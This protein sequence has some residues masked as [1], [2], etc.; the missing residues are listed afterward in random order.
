MKT[1]QY[2]A[3]RRQHLPQPSGSVFRDG[4]CIVGDGSRLYFA[5]ERKRFAR[6]TRRSEK[7]N[8]VLLSFDSACNVC[9]EMKCLKPNV[10]V[11]SLEGVSLG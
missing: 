7:R 5:V 8:L 10:V 1:I 4:S 2:S 6:N 11:E 3:L 9:A